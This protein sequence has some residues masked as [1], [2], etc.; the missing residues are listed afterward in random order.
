MR[1]V[2]RRIFTLIFTDVVSLFST[3]SHADEREDAT[4]AAKV[5]IAALAEKK[6]RLIWD[7]LGKAD[8]AGPAACPARS[9]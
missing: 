5:V 2:N 1:A 8:M 3:A 4:A 7:T 9:R 6:F